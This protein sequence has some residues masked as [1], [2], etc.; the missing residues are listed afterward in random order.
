[1][2][3]I[4]LRPRPLA[5]HLGP[6]P[7]SVAAVSGLTLLVAV[8]IGA[9]AL[10]NPLAPLVLA[11]GAVAAAAAWQRPAVAAVMVIAVAPAISGVQRSL[12]I[13]SLKLSELL[14]LLAFTV[15]L[16]RRPPWGQRLR[17]ADW[18]FAA[19]ALAGAVF[20]AVHVLSGTSG[21][22]TFVRVG[23]QPL[24]LFLTWWTASRAV[25][26]EGDLIRALRWAL[27]ISAVPAALAVLQAFDAPGVRA[28]LIRL[29]GGLSLAQAGTAEAARATGPFPIWHSLAAYLLPLVAVGVAVLL[30]RERR[31]LPRWVLLAVLAVDAAALVLTVTITV[32]A[33]TVVTILIVAALQRRLAEAVVLLVIAGAASMVLFSGPISQRLDQQTLTASPTTGSV[34][35]QT[36]AYRMYIWER[37]YLPLVERSVPYGIGNEL[38]ESVLFEFVENQYLT[39]ALRGG[40]LLLVSA[41]AGMVLVGVSL[42]RIRRNDDLVG[43]V[44]GACLA[45]LVFLP[46][47]AMVWPYLT[48]AGFPQSWIPIAG[49]V[50]GVAAAQRRRAGV[51]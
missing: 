28:L 8:V 51:L 46:F 33:W 10:I 26:T 27:L 1:V 31:V 7:P 5:D 32:V 25:R 39:L 45:V 43:T 34:L 23:L 44:A 42:G 19:F 40:V 41:A 22:G 14:L 36:L 3:D 18:G 2:N 13:G 6:P 37:D 47:A 15:V 50:T 12:G 4:A 16:L 29:T 11:A 48:N 30:R 49:A 17:A 9:T 21:S 24:M 20:G 35:P 38:P